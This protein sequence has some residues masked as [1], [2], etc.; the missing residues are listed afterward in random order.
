MTAT[1]ANC[2]QQL[3]IHSLQCTIFIFWSSKFCQYTY[4][5]ISSHKTLKE[6]SW[7]HR[8]RMAHSKHTTGLQALTGATC[9]ATHQ[10]C[11]SLTQNI[12]SSALRLL[13]SLV[14]V[15]M[16]S[17]TRFLNWTIFSPTKARPVRSGMSLRSDWDRSL[18]RAFGQAPAPRARVLPSQKENFGM[19]FLKV[20][21]FFLFVI[22]FNFW[23]L[24]S[25]QEVTH[26][27]TAFPKMTVTQRPD[28]ALPCKKL[29]EIYSQMISECEEF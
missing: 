7:P 23:W 19:E 13:W 20:L 24:Q 12:I 27:T 21:G 4:S 9:C 3:L 28:K 25:L 15:T 6:H 10:N 16:F 17:M 29:Q 11:I 5:I 26:K 2:L 22:F 18:Q 8:H 14:S 1:S